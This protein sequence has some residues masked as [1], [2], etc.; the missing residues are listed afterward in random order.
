MKYFRSSH[1]VGGKLILVH[2]FGCLEQNKMGFESEMNGL[3]AWQKL[4]SGLYLS[5]LFPW[6]NVYSD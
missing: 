3:G 5:L 4:L 1:F 6:N 2:M